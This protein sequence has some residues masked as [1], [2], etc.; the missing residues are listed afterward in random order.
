VRGHRP[1]VGKLDPRAVK[2]VFVGYFGKQKGYKCWC[3]SE[4][5]MFVSMDVVLREHEPY[6]GEPIDL[7][8]VF[9]DYVTGLDNERWGDGSRED[10]DVAPEKMIV[11][12]IPVGERDRK[13]KNSV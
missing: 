7:T 2:C 3:R 9:P 1:S 8:D 4:K 10:N 11:G 13:Q 6:Y 5:R 12:V